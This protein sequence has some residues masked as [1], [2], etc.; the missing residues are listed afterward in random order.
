MHTRRCFQ[1]TLV[2]G[3]DDL[4]EKLAD[5]TW[6]LCTAFQYRSLLLN[7]ATS[8][9]GAQEFAVFRIP[10]QFV[11]GTI[12]SG[13]Y[14][15]IESITVSWMGAGRLRSYLDEL[16]GGGGVDCG[17][18]HLRLDHGIDPCRFCA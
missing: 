11:D 18:V 3:L 9:D 16:A 4:A 7:D 15:Q 6:T 12:P 5:H 1:V 2:A 10:E 17:V 8:E 14:L 13:T